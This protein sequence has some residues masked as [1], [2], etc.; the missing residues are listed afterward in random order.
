MMFDFC[1]VYKS[2]PLINQVGQKQL[3]SET[4]N[5]KTSLT[6]PLAL[7]HSTSPENGKVGEF[8]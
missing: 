8:D 3:E 7:S 2:K 5:R 1:Q 6:C 4:G